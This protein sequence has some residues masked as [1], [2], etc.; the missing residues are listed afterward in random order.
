MLTPLVLALA[1]AAADTHPLNV[2]DLVA[3]QRVSD[4][5][6]SPDG[7]QV[8]FV[9][10]TTDYEA[11]AGRFDLWIVGAD[12]AGARRLTFHEATDNQP[13]WAPDGRSLY[14]V[15]TRSGS[16][17][18]HRLRFDGGEPETVTRLPLDVDALE[19]APGGQGLVLAMAVFPGATPEA[20][21]ERFAEKKK[22]KASGMLFDRLFVRHWDAWSDGTRSH[23]FSYDL[24]AGKATDLMPQMDADTPSKPFGGSEEYDVTPDGRTLVFA[25]RD[26]G[27]EEAWSTNF[28]LYAVPVDASAA[29]RKLTTN[30]AWDTQPR[31][32]RDGK[33]LAYLAMS[34]AGYE[35]DRFRIVLRDWSTGNERSVDLRADDSPTGDRSPGEIAWSRDG[36]ELFA[37][38][39]HLGQRAVFAV[40]AA[41]GR[42]RLVVK[43]G[44][45]SGVQ[46]AAGGR[47]VFSRTTHDQPA[48]LISVA[49]DGRDLKAVTSVNAEKLTGIRMGAAEQF[50]FPGAHGATVYG[51]L[52][53]PVDFDASKKYPVAFLIHGGPQGS[54]SNEFHYRWNPQ[55]Y[56]GAGYAAVLVDFTGSTGYGQAF[57][58][59]IRG[60]WGGAPYE[61]LMKGLDAALAKYPFLDGSKVCALGASY[62]GY[63]INW[64]AGKTDRFRCL[65]SHDGNLDERAAYYMTE[66]LWFPEWEH[67][68]P[69][70][71]NPAGF[72]KHNPVDGVANWKTP[73]L[74]VHSAR[75][76]RVVDDQGL[77]TFNALQRKGIP[78]QLLFFPDENHWV[79]KPQ[80]SVQWHETVLAWLAR[81][82]E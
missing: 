61:D 10:R 13:R 12:G 44:V 21:A 68:G 25:A 53:R 7:S 16:A 28:D 30:P 43:D 59:R 79:L 76:Y 50:T 8:A 24:A 73:M 33:T 63:M 67:G 75:D 32:S 42:T 46:E 9:L 11:N 15:S 27:R 64:I 35:A 17:Q 6:V 49:R 47:L 1:A 34:R 70:W 55:I 26:A 81:W 20:T 78:S 19:V 48:E 14:F 31:F 60:D 57:T 3:M 4:P 80:N 51:Y 62:G 29:P 2:R 74:V 58:D 37:A 22:S 36:R 65:V 40:D 5:R 52:V 72:A 82:L 38:A 69:E 18:V 45:S 23:L 39:D 54:F 66:E 56:A 71:Q 41:S 77:A